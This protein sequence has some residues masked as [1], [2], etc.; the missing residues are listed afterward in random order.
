MITLLALVAQLRAAGPSPTYGSAALERLI[1]AARDVNDRIPSALAGFSARAEGEAS[2][3]WQLAT[4][5]EILWGG[6]E[7]YAWRVSWSPRK[8]ELHLVGKRGSLFTRRMGVGQAK[9]WLIPHLYGDRFPFSLPLKNESHAARFPVHPF[10]AN[11]SLAYT[12]TGGDTVAQIRSGARLIRLVAIH[13]TPRLDLGEESLFDGDVYLDAD[14]YQ[15]V[16]IVG[17]FHLRA[18][19]ATLEVRV[20]I[21]SAEVDGEFWLPHRELIEMEVRSPLVMTPYVTR[22]SATIDEYAVVRGSDSARSV[23][24]GSIIETSA[25]GDTI[26]DFDRWQRPLTTLDPDAFND[27]I[28]VFSSARLQTSSFPSI[29]IGVSRPAN[30]AHYNRIEGLFTGSEV[31]INPGA[32]APA[33]LMRVQAGYAWSERTVRG[34]LAVERY[35]PRQRV[36]AEVRRALLSTSDFPLSETLAMFGE[37]LPLGHPDYVERS[38][39]LGGVTR[40]FSQSA[41]TFASIRGGIG[42]DRDAPVRTRGLFGLDTVIVP[43]RFASSGRYAIVILD[44]GVG[45][46]RALRSL[47]KSAGVSVH[48]EMASGELTWTRLTGV[49]QFRLAQSRAIYSARIDGG[50]VLSANLPPQQLFEVG[51]VDRLPGYEYKQFVGDRGAVASGTVE[52]P[53]SVLQHGTRRLE[54]RGIPPFAPALALSV[55]G[56]WTALLNSHK[57]SVGLLTRGGTL[58]VPTVTSGVI[59]SGGFGIT[60]FSGLLRAGVARPLERAG[61]WRPAVGFASTF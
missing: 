11:A 31:T 9:P 7:Q 6:A 54:R 12:Y 42:L 56:G 2:N 53:L 20:D 61:L 15:I 43:D 35:G 46:A 45:R 60:L 21:E 23:G 51:G 32:M 52:F 57:A 41:R 10:A 44:A 16:R 48:V 13:V 34:A 26:A 18:R 47:A 28:D 37:A 5:R 33:W 1:E 39:L 38:T 8:Y 50:L 25:A 22:L 19:G 14:R 40:L 59:G 17:R 27:F 36:S 49:S 29:R 3:S 24:P 4:G 55:Q 58:A 30:A